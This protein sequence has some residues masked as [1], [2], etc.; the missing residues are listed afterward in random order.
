MRRR[1]LVRLFFIT[2]FFVFNSLFVYAQPAN[3]NFASAT[4]ITSLINTCSANA[5]YTT[6]AATADQSKGSC[7]SNGPNY[8]VW[9]KFTAT[10]TGYIKVQLNIGGASGTLQNPFVA[11]WDASLTQL[12]CQ[13]YQGASVSIETDYYGLTAGQTYYISVDNYVGTGYRGTF[14]LCLSDVPD[15]NYYEGAKDVTSLINGCSANAAYTTLNATADRSKGS[16][17]SN[18]PNYNR[19][20]KFTATATQYIKV[21][22]NVG[23]ASGTLQNPFVA[24]WDASLTQ[25]NCQNYQGASVSI[26]TDY[27][28]LTAGQTYYISVDNYVGTG[29]RGTFSLCLSDVPDYNYYEGAKDVTSLINGCSANAA[30]TTFNATADRSAGSCWSNGPNYNRWF[31]F[32][33]TATQYIKVQVNVGGASGTLQNPFLALWDASLTQLNCQNYQ[34][35]SV[36]IETDYYGLTAGQT[37]YI[38]VDNYVGT[39]YRGTFSLCLSDVPDY[40]YY[41]GATVLTDLNNWCSANAAYTTLNA[42][43]DKNKGSCWSNGPNYNRWFKFTALNI[44]TTIQV[45]VGGAEG[46]MQNPF[47]ALWASNGTTQL[48]CTNYAGAS[49]DIS[50]TYNSLTIGN[51]YYISVD[52]YVGIGYRGT[53]TL[54]ITNVSSNVFYSRADGDWNTPSTWSNVT[55]GGAAAATAPGV[56]DVANIR[57]NAIT[58]TSAGQCAQVNISTSA[59]NTSLTIDNATL[60]VNGK[61]VNTNTTNNSDI[62]TVQNN[63]TLSVANDFSVTRSGGN[64]NTQFNV[65]SGAVSVGQDMNWISTSGTVSN[66]SMTLSNAAVLSVARDVTLNY[67]GGMK[68]SLNFNNTSSLAIGR[69]L[70]FTSSAASQTEA[71]FNNSSSM[72]IKRNIVRGATPYGMLTFNNS[73]AL[74]FNGTANQQ[75]VAASAGSG[76]DAITY[77]NVTFNNTS[78]FAID[79][80]MG[81]VATIN[82]SLTMTQ[83]VVQT[84]ASNY[85]ALVNACTTTIGST[86]SYIDGPMTYEVATNTANTIRNFPLGNNGA[87]R[88]LVLTVTHTN[89]N[90]IIYTA[91]HFYSSAAALGYTLAPSTDKVSGVRYWQVASSD[92]SNLSSAKVTLYYG[93]GTTDGVSDLPNLTVVKTVGAGTTWVDIG[94]TSATAEPGNIVSGSF[95]S[96]STFTLANLSGGTNP[97]PVEL[98]SFEGKPT[99]AGN[100]L[101]WVTA[102]EI[103]NDYFTLEKSVDGLE[104]YVLAKVQGAGT[105][106]SPSFYK[107]IDTYPTEGISYYKLLQTDFDGKNKLLHTISLDYKNRFFSVFPNP[108]KQ[109]DIKFYYSSTVDESA[110]IELLSNLGKVVYANEWKNLPT[111]NQV[112][113]IGNSSG[114]P[115]GLYFIRV[116]GKKGSFFSK[117]II[118]E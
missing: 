43:A 81:G 52:N 51:T 45:K 89:S 95:S 88:P 32:T 83:G 64:S 39:G 114:F 33:A 109:E 9:F 101:T 46:T 48:A 54:C 96:F 11:L 35:A 82:G 65:T 27:Y 116:S 19:W 69:D 67:S 31:K 30:Y 90:S 8:N 26:E 7:W 61:F 28:G 118:L 57:D 117:V 112:T 23:G 5:A 62:T 72:S 21:Q 10:A 99:P 41:E 107:L 56:G 66:N 76:G 63:G 78:S 100:E 2:A 3:D 97:L 93:Y 80:T 14:S 42:T 113:I 60:T 106:N 84:T 77:N 91:Q 74:T 68:I 110:T 17:W 70:S 55:Y 18:G 38:S 37:Y 53:F 71:I 1:S 16:C 59:A 34:G 47:V 22:V 24:L 85:I 111:T 73:S 29:Y 50:L 92:Q 75:I 105:K 49:V 40:N 86:S 12:N 25:L 104:F 108:V 87:Y 103:N 79:C 13:N 6:V 36:S 44:S 4:D 20:F 15:Y 98:L 58:V 94:Q 115:A 102:S